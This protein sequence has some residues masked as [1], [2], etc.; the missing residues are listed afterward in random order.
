MFA[1]FLSAKTPSTAD[2]KLPHGSRRKSAHNWLFWLTTCCSN[3][4]ILNLFVLRTNFME[5]NFPEMS[6]G[7]GGVMIWGCFKC[8]TF[9]LYFISMITLYTL[10]PLLIH[11]IPVDSLNE[12][13]ASEF[14]H[15]RDSNVIADM[16]ELAAQREMRAMGK[17]LKGNFTYSPAAHFLSC[18]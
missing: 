15:L 7:H 2:F 17:H 10:F 12:H 16:T 9:L 11:Q 4:E 5:E 3:T 1:H 13:S 14:K 6:G 18:I 8:V